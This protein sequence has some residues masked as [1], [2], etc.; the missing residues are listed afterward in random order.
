[1]RSPRR[2]RGG[3]AKGVCV[4][5]GLEV[6]YAKLFLAVQEDDQSHPVWSRAWSSFRLWWFV[7]HGGG[8]E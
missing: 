1:M 3:D 4:P 8:S 5:G 6:L 7:R 2:E